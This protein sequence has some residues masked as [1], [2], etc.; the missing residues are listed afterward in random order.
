M[1]KLFKSLLLVAFFAMIAF[2]SWAQSSTQG[3]EFWVALIPSKGP[4]SSDPTDT[5]QFQPYIAISASN[6]LLYLF[7]FI[8]IFRKFNRNKIVFKHNK[9]F[10][11]KFCNQRRNNY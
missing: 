11:K 8:N 9:Y 4:D 3:K 1:K 2:P 5:K 7:G 6:I 10:Y